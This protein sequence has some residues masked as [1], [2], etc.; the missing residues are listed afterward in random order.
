[1]S[2]QRLAG[3]VAL[4]TGGA[5]GIGAATAKILANEGAQVVLTDI[6]DGEQVAAG[7]GG[8]ATFH[9][10]D[11]TSNQSWTEVMTFATDT[12]GHLDVLVNCAGILD[13]GTIEETT[14]AGWQRVLDVNLKGTF[15]GCRQAVRHMKDDRGGSVVNLSSVSGWSAA[16]SNVPMTPAKGR[17]VC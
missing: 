3:K 9:A 1:M 15:Y 14:L 6:A 2:G 12:F 5:S 17:Y 8:E 10:H 16:P 11:V 13:R 7:I 4:V